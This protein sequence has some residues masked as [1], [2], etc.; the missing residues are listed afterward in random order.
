MVTEAGTLPDWSR[1]V[2]SKQPR[3]LAG[4]PAVGSEGDFAANCQNETMNVGVRII[5][6]F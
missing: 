5:I 6:F 4:L 3:V 1:V 2:R